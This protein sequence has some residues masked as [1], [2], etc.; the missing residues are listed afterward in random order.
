MNDP[1]YS[2]DSV[3]GFVRP[4]PNAVRYFRAILSESQKHALQEACARFFDEDANWLV[5]PP[6]EEELRALGAAWAV[7]T[8]AEVL[9]P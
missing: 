2:G 8:N 6:T 7:L 9:V 4:N 3:E 5:N 1:D